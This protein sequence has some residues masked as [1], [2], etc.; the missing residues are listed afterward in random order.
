MVYNVLL[1]LWLYQLEGRSVI[2][3]RQTDVGKCSSIIGRVC[4]TGSSVV[5]PQQTGERT[6]NAQFRAALDTQ[7]SATRSS[8]TRCL[9]IVMS[10]V[11]LGT[12]IDVLDVVSAIHVIMLTDTCCRR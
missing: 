3:A 5:Y 7:H 11:E 8:T 10:P 9:I 6:N 4:H 12:F 2:T 1:S